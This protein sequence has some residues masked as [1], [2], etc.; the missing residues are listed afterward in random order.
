[1]I[2]AAPTTDGGG[3]TEGVT[4][5]VPTLGFLG[6]MGTATE[7]LEPGGVSI[8]AVCACANEHESRISAAALASSWHSMFIAAPTT[9]WWLRLLWELQWVDRR[10]LAVPPH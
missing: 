10:R 7:A 4:A 1:M 9:V 6:M 3:G 5:G 8:G 2:A